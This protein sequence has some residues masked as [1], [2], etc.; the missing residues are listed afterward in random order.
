MQKSS[1]KFMIML[2]LFGTGGGDMKIKYEKEIVKICKPYAGIIKKLK[3][4]R[5]IKTKKVVSELGEYYASKVL[6]LN[7]KENPV[8]KGYDAID[9]KGKRYQIKTRIKDKTAYTLT[10]GFKNLDNKPFDYFLYVVLDTDFSLLLIYKIYP[11]IVKK[12]LNKRDRTFT[13]SHKKMKLHKNKIK[14]IY[15]K[16]EL[17]LKNAN[18]LLPL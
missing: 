6:K 3:K 17:S 10:G 7:L 11:S 8:K 9:K 16:K 5:V 15:Y 14:E 1:R 2:R 18:P 12:Y 13:F 4:L